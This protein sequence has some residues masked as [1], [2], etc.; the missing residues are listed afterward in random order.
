MNLE[1]RARQLSWCNSGNYSSGI[2][3]VRT[4][5]KTTKDR[6]ARETYNP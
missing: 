6:T 4:E 1:E 5:M 2:L 3:P